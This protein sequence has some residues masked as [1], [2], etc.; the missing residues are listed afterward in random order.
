MTP[1]QKIYWLILNKH[2]SWNDI[3]LLEYPCEVTEDMV[4]A[5][6]SMRDMD[7][8]NDIRCGQVGTNI[9]PEWSRNFETKSVAYQLPD[10]TWVGWTYYYG[11]G[12]H[13]NPECIDW[14]TDSYELSC[15]EEEKVV[16]IQT[17]EKV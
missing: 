12:K 14:I 8:A 11:G 16:I 13:A 15:V 3:P 9:E 6:E 10:N 5:Y 2:N 1:Q 4:E 7:A 17:F